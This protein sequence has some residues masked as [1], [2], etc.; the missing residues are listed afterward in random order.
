MAAKYPCHTLWP[1]CFE[2]CSWRIRFYTNVSG[3]GRCARMVI[4]HWVFV[5]TKGLPGARARD[6]AGGRRMN[7][8]RLNASAFFRARPPRW[9]IAA[10]IPRGRRGSKAKMPQRSRRCDIQ[11]RLYG[12]S[13]VR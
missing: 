11:F 13:P 1:P 6:G 4:C 3:A 10:E 2:S 12:S 5:E 7:Q 9:Y 8:E